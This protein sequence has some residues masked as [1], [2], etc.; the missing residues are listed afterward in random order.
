MQIAI[1]GVGHIGGTLGQKWAKAGHGIVFGVR[2]PEAKR[3]S[4]KFEPDQVK[5]EFAEIL[6]AIDQGEVVV[7]AIPGQ[8]AAQL[9]AD[10][11]RAFDGK[12][13][14][15][16]SNNLRDDEMNCLGALQQ[17]APNAKVFRAFNSLGWEIF[18][19]PEFDGQ[20]ADLLYCGADDIEAQRIVENLIA[21]VGLRPVRVGDLDLLNEVDG[22][23]RVWLALARN[24][25]HGR[26]LAFKVLT[27]EP[28]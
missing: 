22:L 13:V 7:I 24:L 14:I 19:Q 16:A 11:A 10:H 21:D 18:A 17:G 28:L 23:V 20:P 1:L 15:D 12:I 26:H 8:A 9:A 4:I 6:P 25:G 27:D 5:V 3:D 2:D